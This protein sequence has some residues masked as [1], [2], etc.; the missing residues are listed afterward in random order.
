MTS[1]IAAPVAPAFAQAHAPFPPSF[2]PGHSPFPPGFGPGHLPFPPGFGH[3]PGGPGAG[4]HSATATPIEHVILI[5]GENRTFDHVF[6]TYRP[7]NGERINNLLSEGIVTADG[8]PGPNYSKAAQFEGHDTT[9]YEIAP[10]TKTSYVHLPPAMTDGAPSA[11]NDSNPPPFASVPA[12]T[13]VEQQIQD[14]LVPSQ[15][16]LLTTGATGQP[17]DSVDTRIANATTLKNGPYQ[18][19]GPKMPYDSY[20]ASPVHRF[21]QM[22]QQTD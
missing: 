19:T 20:T 15:Y 17:S 16:K 9:T 18:I 7:K 3:G 11:A 6:A 13:A 21:Y 1:L 2:G 22:W 4:E 14:G 10:R 8:T 12:A 5:I